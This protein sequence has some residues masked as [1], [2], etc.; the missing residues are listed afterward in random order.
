MP[1]SHAYNAGLVKPLA[2]S[3]RPRRA[4]HRQHRPTV[5]ARVGADARR[6][7][8]GHDAP[9]PGRR[10]ARRPRRPRS[11]SGTDRARAQRGD[12]GLRARA[13]VVGDES[14]RRQLQQGRHAR[15]ERSPDQRR[16]LESSRVRRVLGR[17]DGGPVPELRP[18][19]DSVGRRAA[20]PAHER[21]FA[22]E[23]RSADVLLRALPG[24]RPR[25]GHRSRSRASGLRTLHSL[26][27]GTDGRRSHGRPTGS[28]SA[29]ARMLL[30]YPEILGWERRVS[31]SAARRFAT[32]CTGA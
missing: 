22:L 20:G 13:R 11:V 8:Q 23:Q 6:V 32:R 24:A 16:L 21:D 27:P 26:R 4:A 2:R 15:R 31:R 18:G 30:R 7:L 29:S 3:R 17:H 5:S 14:R 9:A 10:S 19:R 1:Y 12:E 25:G 28:S